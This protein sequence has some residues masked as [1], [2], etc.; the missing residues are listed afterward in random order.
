MGVERSCVRGWMQRIAI[1]LCDLI[2]ESTVCCV[3]IPQCKMLRENE[4]AFYRVTAARCAFDKTH[5]VRFAQKE[6]PATHLTR[7]TDYIALPACI[8]PFAASVGREL[9]NT[10]RFLVVI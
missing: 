7:K 9:V 8:L 4:G 6:C 10:F 5:A 3:G 2:H 1:F